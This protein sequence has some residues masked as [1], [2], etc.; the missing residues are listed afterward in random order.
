MILIFTA[1]PE[2]MAIALNASHVASGLN[3]MSLPVTAMVAAVALQ[4]E[5]KFSALPAKGKHRR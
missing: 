5:T 1:E 3:S 2:G 4:R